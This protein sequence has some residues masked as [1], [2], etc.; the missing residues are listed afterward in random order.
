MA[1]LV[2]TAVGTLVGGPVGGAIGSLLGTAADRALF[3]PKGARGARLGSLAVQSSAYGSELPRVFGTMRLAGSVIWATDLRE[4]THHEGGGKG[5]ASATAYSYSASFAVAL[6][7]RPIVRVGRIWADGNLL[8][9]AAGDWKSEVGAFRLHTGGEDQAADPLIAAAEGAGGTP[10]Y[11]GLAYAVFE[12]LQ[13]ADYGNRIP[14]L[15]FEVVADDGP[16]TLAEIAAVLS[17]GDVSGAGGPALGGYAA[18]GD[19]VRGAIE[20]L[21][22]ALP[23]AFAGDGAGLRLVDEAAAPV[24]IDAAELGAGG[25]RLTVDHA[26]PGT[27]NEAISIGYYDPA[28]DYQA[29]TQAARRGAAGRRTGTIEL[30]AA[31]PAEDARAI[32]EARLAREWAARATATIGLP[33]RRLGIAAGA[34]VT[35]PRQG[36]RWRVTR[37]SYEAAAVT[38]ELVRLPGGGGAAPLPASAGRPVAQPDRREGAT[39]IELLDLP[40]LGD[41]PSDVPTLLIAAAGAEP[42]W[43]RATV[44]GSSDGGAG[45]TTIGRTAAAAVIGD[46]ATALPPGSTALVDAAAGVEIMLLHDGMA[47]AGDDRLGWSAAMNLAAI[48]DELVQFGRAERIGPA[49]WRLSRLLR[50]RRGTEWAVERH[51]AGERFVL[52]TPETLLAWTLPASAVGTRLSVA[53]TGLGDATPVVA[54][55]DF[56]ARA[57]RPPAPVALRRAGGTLAWTRRSRA[58]WTWRD[59]IDT[60]LAEENERYRVTLGGTAYETDVPVFA[61]PAGAAGPVTVAQI[62]TAAASLPPASLSLTGG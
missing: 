7:A 30:P 31:V 61:L 55:I 4:D 60:P 15:S 39:R 40:T 12:D 23:V 56:A 52:L 11:R 50:G 58:G 6:S 5:R 44:I 51:R 14:S 10:A 59:G 33:P 49:R 26:A 17:D 45:W 19:S 34:I 3:S 37:R 25:A 13:L 2:L 41:T 42:G 18:G 43:R 1:T 27:L 16:V 53:A 35:L 36:G 20:G 21:A 28:R 57:L 48:G 62:G 8:R 38:L 22:Q 9:G 24:A 47:L 29:G 32:A 46:A 54:E